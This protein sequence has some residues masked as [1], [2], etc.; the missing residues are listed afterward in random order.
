M[1]DAAGAGTERMCTG[2]GR[3]GGDVRWN[4]FGKPRAPYDDDRFFSCRLSVGSV[5]LSTCIFSTSAQV[6]LPLLE[7][8]KPP[9]RVYGKRTRRNG[10]APTGT[11]NARVRTF[12]RFHSSEAFR[13]R[14]AGPAHLDA[15]VSACPPGKVAGSQACVLKTGVPSRRD[16]RTISYL[17]HIGRDGLS[18]C[19]FSTLL[20]RVSGPRPGCARWLGL[21]SRFC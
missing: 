10:G 5:H 8:P 11:M 15:A 1:S 21:S 20:F 9:G 16:A 13:R 3:I 18:R 17:A 12:F 6:L 19:D 2:R 7:T 4:K 14:C